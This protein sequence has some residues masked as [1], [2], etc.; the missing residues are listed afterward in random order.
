MTGDSDL[1]LAVALVSRAAWAKAGLD[2]AHSSARGNLLEIL[3]Q[4]ARLRGAGPYCDSAVEFI[5]DL[6]AGDAAQCQSSDG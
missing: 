5:T 4:A 1:W 2:S 6:I 3:N